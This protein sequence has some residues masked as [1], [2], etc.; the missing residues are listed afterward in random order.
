MKFAG[1]DQRQKFYWAMKLEKIAKAVAT[2]MDE[3]V[4]VLSRPIDGS[5]RFHYLN[6]SGN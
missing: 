4:V 3:V 6:L 2:L 5:S 1:D